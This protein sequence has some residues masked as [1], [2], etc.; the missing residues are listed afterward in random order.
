[1]AEKKL[2]DK[3]GVEQDVRERLGFLCSNES[4]MRGLLQNRSVV[5]ERGL[6]WAFA[7][8]DAELGELAF[9]PMV[10]FNSCVLWRR[11]GRGLCWC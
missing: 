10:G 1:M 9:D 5:L 2:Q 6:A 11:F 8:L 7:K 4:T 3:E